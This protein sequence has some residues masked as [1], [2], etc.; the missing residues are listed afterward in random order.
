MPLERSA[1]LSPLIPGHS[2]PSANPDL[3]F[4]I[5]SPP[6]WSGHPSAR[7]CASATQQE[8]PVFSESPTLCSEWVTANSCA[9]LA[10]HCRFPGMG[11]PPD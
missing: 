10:I 1:I 8:T 3:L 7:N 5:P 11:H 6:F 4:H 9:P 2:P